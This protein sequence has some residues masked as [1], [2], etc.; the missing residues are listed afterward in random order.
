MAAESLNTSTPIA[1]VGPTASGKTELAL[2][3]A[4]RIDGEILSVD[5]GQLYRRLDAG[6][7]KPKGDWVDG[8]YRVEGIPYHLVDLLDPSE[9]SNAGSYARRARSVLED[10]RKRGKRPIFAGGT[11]L[12]LRAIID[13]L[14]DL[15]QGDPK[16]RRRLTERIEKEGNECLHA[17]LQIND[18]E[19]A[20]RIPPGNTQRLLRALEVIEI[21]GGKISELWSRKKSEPSIPVHYIG[22]DW[23]VENLKGRIRRRAESMF[24]AMIE[25]VTQLV[26]QAFTGEEPG[27]LCLGYPQALATADR[28]L[29]REE[30]LKIMISQTYAYAKRQRTWFRNQTPV[31]WRP[32]PGEDFEALADDFI[33]ELP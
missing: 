28:R 1:V 18:P 5:R 21:T 14:D 7:A 9:T 8:V 32:A 30:G 11:G 20:R 19:A 2:A 29:S 27:F 4:R 24:P 17:E 10:I 23:S 31:L 6:T 25:E 33:K 26:P 13:G 22:P 16:I 15:P 3:L 12:Y